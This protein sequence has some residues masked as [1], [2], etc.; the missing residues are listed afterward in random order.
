MTD[1]AKPSGPLWAWAD[2]AGTVQVGSISPIEGNVT[3]FPVRVVPGHGKVVPLE[4]VE[5]IQAAFG[6][7]H[8]EWERM[9]AVAIDLALDGAM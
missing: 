8:P 9:T 1:R 2:S 5:A 4:L 7:S 3:R 6:A